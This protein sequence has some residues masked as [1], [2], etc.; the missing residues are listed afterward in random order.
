[1]FRSEPRFKTEN[2]RVGGSIPPRTTIKHSKSCANFFENIVAHRKDQ[3]FRSWS[4]IYFILKNLYEFAV[5]IS[6]VA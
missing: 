6:F 1:M 3:E 2:P 4:L 5:L